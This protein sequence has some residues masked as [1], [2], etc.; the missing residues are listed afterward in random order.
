MRLEQHERDI[1]DWLSAP[2]PSSNYENALEKRHARTGLWF[3]SSQVFVDWKKQPN[4][5]LWL[6]G[7]PGAGKTVLSSTII[8]QLNIVSRPGQV[9]LY[10]YFAFNDTNKQTLEN[11]LRSL[12]NQLYQKLPQTREPLEEL[13]ESSGRGNQKSSRATLRTVLSA[14]LSKAIDASIV[15]DALDESTTRSDLLAWLRD[16][17]QVEPCTFRILV[18]ARREE[19]IESALLRWMR[20]QDSISVRGSDVDGDI[21]NYIS[22]T[23][24]NSEEL[25]RWRKMPEVQ[26]EIKT[27]LLE[28]ADGM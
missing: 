15:L 9:L 13:W 22:H 19:E 28:K 10:F 7:I 24:H 14:M 4:S 12:L 21:R 5:F 1:R 17:M 26:E 18:T 6:H 16:A 8:E 20:P 25:V 11:M 23:V 2:D 27:R 3:T